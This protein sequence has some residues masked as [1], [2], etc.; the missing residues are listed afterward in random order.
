MKEQI[1]KALEAGDLVRARQLHQ[2]WSHE[3]VM[4]YGFGMPLSLQQAMNE[5]ARKIEEQE[6]TNRMENQLAE[7]R[8]KWLVPEQ[9]WASEPGQR[10]R[11]ARLV[12]RSPNGQL[13]WFV[14][15][16]ME[17]VTV[18]S[19]SYS[20]NGKWSHD[21]FRLKVEAEYAVVPMR[22]GFD[23]GTILGGLGT[24]VGLTELALSNEIASVLQV[25]PTEVEK[26]IKG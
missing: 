7:R 5:V 15:R 24:A 1:E 25:E 10:S 14:G 22:D 23:N 21:K 13:A 16:T 4:K 3:S 11:Q 12:V 9:T 8:A 20:K 19:K 6:R 2:Q 17:G 18:L 26:L